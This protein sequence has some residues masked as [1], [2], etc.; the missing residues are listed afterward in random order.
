[1]DSDERG[2]IGSAVQSLDL[3]HEFMEHVVIL[4]T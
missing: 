4:D 2:S 1:M 3:R